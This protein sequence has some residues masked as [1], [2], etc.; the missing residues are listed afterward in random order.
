MYVYIH[1]Y[2]YI[3]LS[4]LA[5]LLFCSLVCLPLGFLWG[6]AAVIRGTFE[7]HAEAMTEKIA[8]RNLIALA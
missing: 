8:P 1:I 6:K 2:I 5:Y 4:A 3:Y 7:I